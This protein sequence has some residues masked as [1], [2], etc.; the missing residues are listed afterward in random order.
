MDEEVN[1]DK[2]CE[3]DGMNLEVDSK[4]EVMY[5]YSGPSLT[6]S[7][8]LLAAEPGCKRGLCC[9]AASVSSLSVTFVYCV[10]TSKHS[11]FLNFFSPSGSH[12]ILVFSTKLYDNILSGT[13]NW[14]K[15]EL[16]YRKHIERQLCTQYVEGIY[17]PKHY[18]MTL[19]CRLEVTH[20]H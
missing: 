8:A 12:T 13:P 10:E 3:A 5:V 20:G 15:Q 2:N 7:A 17:R 16:S 19:K 18:T 1:Q 4:D 6:I 14:D 11:L 9:R